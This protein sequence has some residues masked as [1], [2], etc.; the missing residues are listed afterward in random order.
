MRAVQ[1]T[2]FGD[3]EVLEPGELP[4][5]V[6]GHGQLVIDVA[7]APVLFIDTVIRAGYAGDFFPD[8]VPPWVPGM[9][10]AG[11]VASVGEG[12]DPAWVGR[13]AVADTPGGGGYAEQAA[14]PADAVVAVPEALDLADA[15]A[16]LHDG[17]TALRLTEVHVPEAGDWVLV[18]GAAGAAALLITQ[19]ARRA[20]ARVVGAARGEEKLARAR[21]CGAEA[22]VDYT[23]PD[24]GQQ[25]RDLT[26][27]TGP[28]IVFDGVGGTIGQ[29]AFELVADG[30]RISAHG[31]PGG[32]FAPIDPGLAEKRGI[33]ATGIEAVH[34]GPE[35]T[36]RLIVA[37]LD[38]AASKQFT[39]VIG[40]TL[41]LHQAA[42]AHRLIE[43]RNAIGKVLLEVD[44]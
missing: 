36:K 42:E 15:A 44:R 24:W 8:A 22:V 41:P 17:R 31:T 18:T 30:G 9:G 38:A 39:P 21:A 28:R 34:V 10:V 19:L 3:P 43:Q 20:G 1:V 2:S 4:D 14:A 12:V 16:V 35:D 33:T 6:A 5:P 37:A 25:V 32:G 11:T 40:Q 7:F 29:A 23:D 13:R 26:G 27:G